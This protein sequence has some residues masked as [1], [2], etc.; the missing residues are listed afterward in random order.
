[1]L[2]LILWLQ[3]QTGSHG[4]AFSGDELRTAMLGVLVAMGGVG[5]RFL[6]GTR[7]AV[8]DMKRDLPRIVR[9]IEKQEKD[10]EWLIR[11][12]L[13]QDAEERERSRLRREALAEAERESRPPEVPERRHHLRRD[14]DRLADTYEGFPPDEHP[15]EGSDR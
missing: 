1:M 5:L 2:T 10:I 12:R 7:D 13:D 15:P 9:V 14:R 11:R 6:W 3:Q 4:I 8:R